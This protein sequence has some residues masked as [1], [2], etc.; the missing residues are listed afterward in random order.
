MEYKTL[1]VREETHRKIKVE[2]AKAGVQIKNFVDELIN[3][4]IN[5]KETEN[6]EEE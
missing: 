6:K 4:Y 3:N 5:N 1:R 2:S